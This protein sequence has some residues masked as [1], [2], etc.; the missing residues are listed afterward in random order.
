MLPSSGD[1]ASA[2]S[3]QPPRSP[4][5]NPKCHS[6]KT[7]KPPP[8]ESRGRTQGRARAEICESR[9]LAGTQDESRK[10]GFRDTLPPATGRRADGCRPRVSQ[11]GREA[12]KK[13][14]GFC[15][16]TA[17]NQEK[18]S[19][20]SPAFS[21]FPHSREFLCGKKSASLRQEINFFQQRNPVFA[22][23]KRAKKRRNAPYGQ[24]SRPFFMYRRD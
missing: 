8:R 22:A 12:C 24:F 18:K 1:T 9:G 23:R 21:C 7:S 5:G 17:S 4:A 6:V 2:I 15:T 20:R 10:P 14:A 16:R 19:A 3:R 11:A 13:A